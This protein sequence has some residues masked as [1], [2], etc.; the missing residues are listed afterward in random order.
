LRISLINI[1]FLN[2]GVELWILLEVRLFKEVSMVTSPH[3]PSGSSLE[4][5]LADGRRDGTG[6]RLGLLGAAF[7]HLV[8]FS[9][10][11]PTLA[12]SAPEPTP[13]PT[14]RVV[15]LN[16]FRKPPPEF[17]RPA[18][19]RRRVP[20][21]AANPHEPVIVE[22]DRSPEITVEEWPDVVDTSGL[23][24]PPEPEQHAE[25]VAGIDVEPPRVIHRVEPRYTDPAIHIRQ[26]G[27]V[28][29]SLLIDR[30]GRVADITVLRG[31]PFGLTESAVEA[32]QQWQF[33]PC[34]FNGRTVSVR[35]TLTV[36]FRLES[37][38]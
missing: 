14:Y 3:V 36:R 29:L 34:T 8:A 28:I 27:V 1:L 18:M 12:R 24:P 23:A 30:Q 26:E 31:L 21:P 33:E 20:I 5:L 16:R 11:W 2:Q 6:I 15:Q 38:C 4:H 10:T 25:V 19:P 9:V 7:V 37:G 35:Y 13:R 32:V 17:E 22:R